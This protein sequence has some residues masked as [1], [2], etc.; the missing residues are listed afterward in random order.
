[1]TYASEDHGDAELVA[2]V[3]D[4]LVADAAAWLNDRGDA[5]FGCHFDVVSEWEECIRSE[6]GAFGLVRQRV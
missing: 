6:H 1:M 2:G 4:F 5:G 3:D